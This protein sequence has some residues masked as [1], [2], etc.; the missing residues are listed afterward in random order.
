VALAAV[1]PPR[2][3]RKIQRAF[4]AAAYAHR[5]IIE[6]FFGPV[7]AFRRVATRY[8]KTAAS[9]FASLTLATALLVLTG[10]KP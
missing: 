5:N 2:A 4:D 10:W 6:G 8:D 3:N 1:I 7:K 9:H